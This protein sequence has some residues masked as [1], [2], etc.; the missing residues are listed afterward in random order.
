MNNGVRFKSGS[1][2]TVVLH[3]WHKEANRDKAAQNWKT[4]T[5]NLKQPF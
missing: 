3:L 1:F 5:A 2:A 4:A